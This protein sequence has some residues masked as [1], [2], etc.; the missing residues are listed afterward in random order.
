MPK[1][2]KLIAEKYSQIDKEQQWT[3]ELKITFN[4]QEIIAITITDHYQQKPG[5]EWITNELILEVIEN[6]FHN[7]KSE[8]VD[9]PGARKVFKRETTYQNKRYRFF[10]WFKDNTTNH[11]WIKNCHPL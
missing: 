9:Y 3:H 1:P 6:R 11:L 5:R 7:K 10:F 4:F 2:F 8:S